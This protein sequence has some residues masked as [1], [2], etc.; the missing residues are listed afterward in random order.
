MTLKNPAMALEILDNMDI[1]PEDERSVILAKIE[2]LASTQQYNKALSLV[3]GLLEGTPSDVELQS[4]RDA[5]AKKIAEG[6]NTNTKTPS[7]G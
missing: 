1:G 7:F 2:I 5:I 3:D 6:Q 4:V